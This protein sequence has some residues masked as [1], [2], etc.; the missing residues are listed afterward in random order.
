MLTENDLRE[1]LEY[2]GQNPVI[3]VY[4]NLE[5]SEGSADAH[6]LRLRSMLKEAEL[7]RD[8]EVIERFFDHEF[9]WTGRSIALFSSAPEGWFRFYP[10]AIPLRSRVRIG[11]RPHVKPLVDIL[12]AFGGYGVALVD[13]QGAR[14]FYFHLGELIEQEGVLGESVRHTKRG[15]GSQAQGR[16]GG[17]AGQTNYVE[18]VT[19]R[20]AREA[21]DFAAKFFSEKNVRRIVI[22]G[23]DDNI[24][25]FR[26][27]LP[28]AWQSLVIGTFPMSMT[29]SHDEVL[30]RAMEIG[31]EAEH[32]REG[33]LIDAVIT[34]AA[35][36]RGGVVRM[37]ET[38]KAVQEGR[39]QTLFIREGLRIAGNHCTHC[40]AM[41]VQLADSCPSCGNPLV[42]TPDVVEMA[43][44]K[45]LES[46]G[47]V[48]VLHDDLKLGD[49][50]HIG[51]LLRY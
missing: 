4:L 16:R 38:L 1:L 11:D 23:T 31:L 9:D 46:G 3:S 44:K 22:G 45:V 26:S 15:G 49:Y 41:T 47:E 24:T 42:K 27:Q 32:R 51:G 33:R 12:D 50:E 7:P 8:G 29:A 17:V 37:E 14:F 5:P 39:V 34:S 25:Y 20:N 10:L 2:K 6:K 28:K 48:E 35:K 21:A 43:V 13:K 36:G 19:E 18:E 40:G 30:G